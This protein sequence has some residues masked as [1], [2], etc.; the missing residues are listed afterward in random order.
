[1]SRVDS[2]D[3][4]RCGRTAAYDLALQSQLS[5]S[6]DRHQPHHGALNYL[7][8]IDG[9]RAIAILAVVTYHAIPGV[10]PGGFAGVDIFFVISGFLITRLI[11]R[12][13]REKRF[14]LPKFLL[15][16]ARRLLPAAIACF[17]L[18][19]SISYFVLLPVDFQNF[20][21]SMMATI[22]M[23]SNLFYYHL[24]G[25]FFPR[26]FE[27]PLLHTWS[28][29]VEDQ[30]YITWPA[31]LMLIM[32]R[33]SRASLLAI[34]TGI[35]TLSLA[36]AV[37]KTGADPEW[38]FFMLPSRAWELLLGCLLGLLYTVSAR[39]WPP[40]FAEIVGYSG[41]VVVALSL[42]LLDATSLMPGLAAVP[43]CLGVAAL[44]A[45]S[46][47]HETF[48]RRALSLQLPVFVGRISYSLYLFHWPLLA[49]ATYGLE[50]SLSPIEA[51]VV[52]AGSLIIAVVSWTYI[53]RPFRGERG[54]A[55]PADRKFIL[56]GASAAAALAF[57]GNA[58]KDYDG[59]TWRYDGSVGKL[60]VQMSSTN[61]R[62]KHCDGAGNVFANDEYCNV[63]SRRR[64]SYDVALFGDSMANQWAPLLE[65]A[66]QRNG[67]AARQV[68]NG[69]CAF[70]P[71]V[72]LPVKDVKLRECAQYLTQALKFID[73]NP[74][75]KLAIVSAYWQ[76]WKT[77]LDRDPLPRTRHL[78]IG[79]AIASYAGPSFENA[80]VQMIRVFRD[81]GIKVHI[82]GPVASL[83]FRV[84]CIIRAAREDLKFDVCGVPAEQARASLEPINAIFA[85]AAANDPGVSYSLPPEFMCDSATCSPVIDN[86]IVYR[87]DGFHLNHE[88]A[89]L[90]SKYIH[91]PS[92]E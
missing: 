31:I 80:V 36:I 84:N 88:G 62:R 6:S 3:A 11:N 47:Q 26:A 68:T 39:V 25:Y 24:S 69:G 9:L 75:L 55:W 92:L 43:I 33:L 70:F 53:E 22:L 54:R 60:L 89:E 59:W 10:L 66:S 28:L 16:R 19:L 46:M 23:Y 32:P 18:T 73:A 35:L 21:R 8:F 61:P 76:T 4:V 27:I 82:I 12:E 67:W 14:S 58:I 72:E 86:V 42:I 34:V 90:L 2:R 5:V 85:Q 78:P 40:I 56:A 87:S 63:G 79:A 38:A 29:A 44:I 37:K 83:K 74:G 45:S 20:G 71:G 13:I 30:F 81:R 41:L 49:L 50:R 77:R 52:V 15:R 51:V 65:A 91:V 17:A 7:P 57:V 1:M 64:S 48:V